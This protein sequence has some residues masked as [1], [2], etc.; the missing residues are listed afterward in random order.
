MAHLNYKSLGIASLLLGTISQVQASSMS[1]CIAHQV[2]IGTDNMTLGEIRRICEAQAS[3][4][5]GFR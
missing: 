3:M 1:E 4:E 2:E 5:S